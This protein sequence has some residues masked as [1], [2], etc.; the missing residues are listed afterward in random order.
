MTQGIV[1][2]IEE[3]AVYDGPGIRSV[4]FLKGCPLRCKWCHNPE[5]FHRAPERL[6]S[7]G[8]CV[9]CGA[10]EAV[11]GHKGGCI[12]CGDCVKVCPRGAL[13]IAG[14]EMTPEEVARRILKNAKVLRMSGGGVTFSGGEALMQP[15]FVIETRALLPSLHA[16][17]ETSG[18]ADSS[19]FERVI[20]TMDLVLMD[21]KLADPDAHRRWTG[22]DNRRILQNLAWLKASGIPFRARVPLIPRVTDTVENLTATA[23]LLTGAKALE[24]VELMGYNRAAGAKYDQLGL[25]YEPGFQE[26]EA[27]NPYTQP[28]I[29]RGMEV[30][31][32]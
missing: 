28:F 26:D 8:L 20:K 12:A 7:R 14:R 25:A 17:I 5:S 9:H 32:L 15:D 4:I 16:A 31:T 21:V 1:F 2:D 29:E 27:P 23:W 30:I 6:K 24:R 18:Y 22:V 3:F 11:C 10:C 13:R 19:I